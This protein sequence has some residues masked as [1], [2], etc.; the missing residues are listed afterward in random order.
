MTSYKFI[1]FVSIFYSPDKLAYSRKGARFHAFLTLV[2]YYT[3]MSHAVSFDTCMLQYNSAYGI[4][5]RQTH[6]AVLLTPVGCSTALYVAL[7]QSVPYHWHLQ[8]AGSGI[9]F[10]CAITWKP[11]GYRTA[12]CVVLRCSVPCTLKLQASVKISIW[13]YCAIHLTPAGFSKGLSV[14]LRHIVSYT[15]HLQAAVQFCIRDPRSRPSTP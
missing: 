15:C 8:A 11:A 4:Y 5:T 6:C 14:A 7:R 9:Y 12:L 13:I 10:Y 1:I 3:W 2:Q